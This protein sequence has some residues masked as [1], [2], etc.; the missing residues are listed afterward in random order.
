MIEKA[1]QNGSPLDTDSPL[2]SDYPIGSIESR[3]AARRQLES[4][5][6]PPSIE[7]HF[8]RP[9]RDG[10]GNNVYGGEEC[11]SHRAKIDDVVVERRP[12]ESLAEFKARVSDLI[13][14]TGV[15]L[16]WMVPD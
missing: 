9:V 7:F 14:V 6:E 8:V 3:A 11:D 10:D 1:R 15:H 13:P 16:I 12:E 4:S 2:P 5:G